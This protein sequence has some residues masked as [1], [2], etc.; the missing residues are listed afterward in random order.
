MAKVKYKISKQVQTSIYTF[1]TNVAKKYSNTYSLDLMAKNISNVYTSIYKI[2][3]G[4]MRRKPTIKQWKGYFMANTSKWHFAYKIVEDTIYIEDARHSQN[5]SEFSSLN[6]NSNN[7]QQTNRRQ[8]KVQYKQTGEN[9]FGYRVVKLKGYDNYNLINH[10]GTLLCT[11]WFN[12]IHPLPNLYGK[13]KIMAYINVGGLLYA[14]SKDG[15]VYSLNNLHENVDNQT[16]D[17]KR[18]T[19]VLTE[20]QLHSIIKESIN[21]IISENVFKS[22]KHSDTITLTN[23]KKVKCVSKLSNGFDKFAIGIDDGCYVIYTQKQNGT[24]E[25]Y[26]STYIFPELYKELRRLPMLPKL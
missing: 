5:M 14:L 16:T 12:A 22:I 25:M 21:R 17:N 9:V 24:F 20:L 4:L 13:Y 18:T 6:M 1:Y 11:H 23:G 7:K 26:K 10:D 15:K 19:I 2:E 3:N 8:K